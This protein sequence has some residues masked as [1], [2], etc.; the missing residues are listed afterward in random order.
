MGMGFISLR[1]SGFLEQNER[2][3]VVVTDW[4]LVGRFSSSFRLVGEGAVDRPVSDRS[5][6]DQRVRPRGAVGRPVAAGD[7]SLRGALRQA[8][9]LKSEARRTFCYSK[10]ASCLPSPRLTWKLP[11]PIWKT[12]FHVQRPFGSFRISLRE[13]S[14]ICTLQKLLAG[15]SFLSFAQGDG[16][17]GVAQ[18]EL[19]GANRRF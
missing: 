2:T 7:A 12:W 4:I 11:G 15:V 9:A 6:G 3:E 1:P 16:D 5:Q 14:R 10:R 19:A 13:C 8:E 18:N 17:M